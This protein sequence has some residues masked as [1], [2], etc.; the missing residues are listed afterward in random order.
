[1]SDQLPFTLNSLDGKKA[2]ALVREADFA[3]AGD[4]ESIDMVFKQLP[5][6]PS[7]RVL[8]AGSGLGATADAIRHEGWGK[9]TGIEISKGSVI[10][11]NE[12]YPRCNF[13]H[14]DVAEADQLVEPGFDIVVSF[15]AFY[16]FSD[17]EGALRAMAKVA[18]PDAKL[19]IFDYVDRGDYQSEPILENG[20]P[21]I[22]N[23]VK[24]DR[25]ERMLEHNGWRMFT[26]EPL[27]PHFADW[28]NQ[29]IDRIVEKEKKIKKHT[30]EGFFEHM[31][32][33]YTQVAT[34]IRENR[35]G[36]AIIRADLG[37][38]E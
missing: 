22:P 23:P 13:V 31:L 34:A 33:T 21:L 30:P 36:G 12:T 5:R 38:G 18:K 32:S 9:V 37:K 20:E 6:D 11:A 14:G 10:Y 1:M 3:H 7:K 35:L 24:L 2:L 17:Q 4:R 29:L 27:H 16:A 26:I 15:N 28:Y 25:I 19:A 8:D